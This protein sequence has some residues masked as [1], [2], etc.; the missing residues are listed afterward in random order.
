VVSEMEGR[1]YMRLLDDRPRHCK[2]LRMRI[3][4]KFEMRLAD[5]EFQRSKE[6]DS[7]RE[8]REDYV[9][10][11]TRKFRE[12]V[13]QCYCSCILPFDHPRIHLNLSFV[14]QL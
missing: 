6:E 4:A 9:M 10:E 11:S 1:G 14:K 8:V 3:S 13:K 7:Y 2:H 5:K 12:A